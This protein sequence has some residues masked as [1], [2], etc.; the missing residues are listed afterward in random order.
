MQRYPHL[1]EA[2]H[3]V[4]TMM[5]ALVKSAGSDLSDLT[6]AVVELLREEPG[7]FEVQVVND[8]NEEMRPTDI[9]PTSC[10][11]FIKEN[12]LRIH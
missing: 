7:T 12:N 10:F 3:Y 11:L 5:P 6:D 9:L 2:V 4:S 8:D 1:I